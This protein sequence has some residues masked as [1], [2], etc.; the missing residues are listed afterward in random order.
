MDEESQKRE[1]FYDWLTSDTKAEFINGEIIVQSPAKKRHTTASMNLSALLSAYVEMNDLGF[2]GAETVLISLTR[3][4]YL[5]DICFFGREKAAELESE[6]MKFPAPDFIV[7]ILSP[8]TAEVDR[9]VKFEDYAAHEVVEYWLV[10]PELET[11]EQYVLEDD[12]FKLLLKVNSGSLTSKAVQG[13]KIPVEAIFD[14]KAK[15]QALA[16]I[17]MGGST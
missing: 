15:N 3:N 4:D 2:V 17:L 9:G 7:E 6:Q 12:H 16:A 11:V 1:S 13:F 10:D 5:P 8:T 14:A